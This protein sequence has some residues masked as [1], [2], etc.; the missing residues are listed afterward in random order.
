[1]ELDNITTDDYIKMI[2]KDGRVKRGVVRYVGKTFF[3]VT[4]KDGTNCYS[5]GQME[6]IEQLEKHEELCECN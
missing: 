2:F 4:C 6:K 1:M 3:W 5:I